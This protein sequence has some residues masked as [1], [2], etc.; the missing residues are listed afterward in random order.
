MP[1]RPDAERMPLQMKQYTDLF[2]AG[3]IIEDDLYEAM[4][5]LRQPFARPLTQPP[6]CELAEPQW[7]PG[8]PA[9]P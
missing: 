4:V 3:K 6:T 7:L 2:I 8:P 9:P 1:H 5:R